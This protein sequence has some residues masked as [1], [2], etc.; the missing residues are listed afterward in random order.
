MA[1]TVE[2]QGR[3]GNVG[4]CRGRSHGQ[5]S[6]ADPLQHVVAG[7]VVAGDDHNPFATPGTDPIFGDC[8]CLGS[9]GTCAVDLG[10]GTSRP[11]VLGKLGVAEGNCPVQEFPVE[12]VRV[13]GEI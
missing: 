1:S 6:G 9:T 4:I 3:I 5:E 7:H 12:G 13:G 11:D 2:R 10:V 8:H